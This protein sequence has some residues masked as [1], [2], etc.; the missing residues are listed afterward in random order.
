M[1]NNNDHD[2]FNEP[3]IPGPSLAV[4]S[5]WKIC[6]CTTQGEKWC[7]LLVTGW[8][9]SSKL[10][11]EATI[12]LTWKI[13]EKFICQGKKKTDQV[14][15]DVNTVY[16]PDSGA[17]HKPGILKSTCKTYTCLPLPQV[18]CCKLWIVQMMIIKEINFSSH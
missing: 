14:I 18:F 6:M 16:L 9:I 13:Y 15:K 4:V 2:K 17:K 10:S 5:R 7:H 11:Q 3:F 1:Q 8:I 12:S